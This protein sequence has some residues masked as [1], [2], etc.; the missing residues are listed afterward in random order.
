[1]VNSHPRHNSCNPAKRLSCS[2]LKCYA[3]LIRRET[4]APPKAVSQQLSLHMSSIHRPLELFSDIQ[5]PM[6]TLQKK[7]SSFAARFKKLVMVQGSFHKKKSLRRE[8][9]RL[10][11]IEGLSYLFIS[12]RNVGLPQKI[13][14]EHTDTLNYDQAKIK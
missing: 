6:M 2:E 8:C 3:T 11:T 9:K 13:Q 10:E 7:R 5:D 4:Q 1:M 12:P 14:T